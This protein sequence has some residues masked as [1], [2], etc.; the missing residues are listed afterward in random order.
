MQ[1]PAGGRRLHFVYLL[2]VL[3]SA[4]E[5]SLVAEVATIG[6]LGHHVSIISRKSRIRSRV[7]RA[8]AGTRAQ[9]YFVH[10]DDPWLFLRAIPDNLAVMLQD[11]LEFSRLYRIAR[12]TVPLTSI[13]RFLHAGM[14]ARRVQ[15]IGADHLHFLTGTSRVS[16]FVSSMCG[17][18]YSTTAPPRDA[19][20][21]DEARRCVSP[22]SYADHRALEILTRVSEA[23]EATAEVTIRPQ[24]L[25]V[26]CPERIRDVLRVRL[27]REGY[28]VRDERAA[29]RDLDTLLDPAPDVV[30]AGVRADGANVFRLLSH[31]RNDLADG[32][33]PFIMMTDRDSKALR[34]KA[35]KQG[36][37]G[38]FLASSDLA[39]LIARIGNF[40]QR[41]DGNPQPRTRPRRTGISGQLDTLPLP[42][43]VQILTMGSK[44]ACVTVSSRSGLGKLWFDGGA[45]VHCR[46]GSHEG[47]PA[48]YEMMRWTGG[49]F[50]IEHDVKA[51][52]KTIQ[53]DAMFLVFEALR[54]RDE[55]NATEKELAAEG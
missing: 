15:S 16:R 40:L 48:F 54:Q 29:D 21:R 46:L 31:V 30:L 32:R 36:V 45:L 24:V 33:I 1:I 39:E 37:D 4:R 2:R 49:E 10:E 52:K 25:L 50:K 34:L 53:N 27:Q 11:P 20:R 12:T 38:F 28:D 8:F 22:G 44:T 51:T 13:R 3:S 26:N 41:G 18:S 35:F 42:E 9:L 6:K 55:A 23:P 7:E 47:E 5:S 43:I 17:L 19:V 14:I